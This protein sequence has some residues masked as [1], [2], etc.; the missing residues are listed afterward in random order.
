MIRK[1]VLILLACALLFGC[2]AQGVTTVLL[3]ITVNETPTTGYKWFYLISDAEVLSVTDHGY[4][5]AEG[6]NPILDLQGTHT[7]TVSGVREGVASVTFASMRPWEVLTSDPVFTYTFEVGAD[8]SLKVLNIERFPEDYTPGKTM[9]RLIENPTTGYRW[10]IEEN[11]DGVLRMIV[12]KYEQDLSSQSATGGG[13]VHTWVYS[14]EKAGETTLT[15]RYV[16]P[17]GGD[18]KPAATVRFFFTVN[19]NLQVGQPGIDGDY[20]QFNPYMQK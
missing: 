3:D 2:T 10:E 7:W 18:G 8:E 14:G 9:I 16:G 4:G 17:S 13:G 19:T 12:D 6:G 15:F 20:A 11:P 1:P 5:A